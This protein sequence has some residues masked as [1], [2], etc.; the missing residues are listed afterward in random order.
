MSKSAD[1]RLAKAIHR[2]IALP[3]PAAIARTILASTA[4]AHN[5]LRAATYE[6]RVRGTGID[7]DSNDD[8]VHLTQTERLAAARIDGT[9]SHR[10]ELDH[11]RNLSRASQRFVDGIGALDAICLDA[12]PPDTWDQAVH[13][14]NLLCE[15]GYVTAALD[16]G[17]NVTGWI[18]QVCAA[19]DTI[20]AI[21]TRYQP[22]QATRW[23]QIKESGIR[24]DEV[25]D[26][27]ASVTP[28]VYVVARNKAFL[29]CRHCNDL[30][31]EGGERPTR[32][33]KQA[34]HHGSQLD[35]RRALS[36]WLDDCADE[37]RAH[38]A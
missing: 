21:H 34:Y 35:Y 38:H 15:A 6:A 12:P 8:Q 19:V 32:E 37:R 13:E 29:L 28:P 18:N 16:V 20:A 22:H 4:G 27:C 1:L 10:I 30:R 14:A 5:G 17:H 2:A 3:V 36:R 9:H 7:S 25:C 26:V 23:Q 11:L 33:V 31:L 24:A